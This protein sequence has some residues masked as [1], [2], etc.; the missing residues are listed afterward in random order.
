MANGRKGVIVPLTRRE[1]AQRLSR[2]EG[3]VK[4]IKPMVE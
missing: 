4:G 1:A 2:I 3:Q